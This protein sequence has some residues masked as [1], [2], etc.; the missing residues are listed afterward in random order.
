DMNDPLPRLI[1]IE[2]LDAAGRGLD[3][4]RGEQ[5]LSDLARAGATMCGGNGVIRRCESQFRI[6]NRQSPAL[7]IKKPARAAEIVQQMAVDMEEISVLAEVG[8]DVLVPDL[9]QHRTA[10]L[11][12]GSSPFA[13]SRPRPAAN[14]RLARLV[15]KA[16]S[17]SIKA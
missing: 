3:P 8:D 13:F 6:M 5:F 14:H 4:K 2:H 17:S 15:V 11:S 1:D 16:P 10:G 9:G 7:E 12:Q